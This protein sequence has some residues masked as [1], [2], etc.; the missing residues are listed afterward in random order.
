[1]S[2]GT[3]IGIFVNSYGYEVLVFFSEIGRVRGT[4][5]FGGTG[6]DAD[7]GILSNFGQ[8]YNAAPC[9]PLGREGK[10]LPFGRDV[11]L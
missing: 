7:T 6:S 2:T 9:R 5:I 1:M 10:S 4:G 11:S 3:G 8:H